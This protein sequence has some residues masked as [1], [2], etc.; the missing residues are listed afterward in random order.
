MPTDRRNPPHQTSLAQIGK[1]FALALSLIAALSGCGVTAGVAANLL[2]RGEVKRAERIADQAA[3]AEYDKTA[4][5]GDGANADDDA[6]GEDRLI[7][8]DIA[9]LNELNRQELLLI[10]GEPET[11]R[12]QDGI[13]LDRWISNDCIL[14]INYRQP[15]IETN[16]ETAQPAYAETRNLDGDL[17][18]PQPCLDAVQAN[19]KRTPLLDVDTIGTAEN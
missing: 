15:D 6:D 8:I 1:R 9:T 2:S 14:D 17:S 19:A 18:P 12:A 5:D 11:A 16:N 3:E 10:F 13:W 4:P 7:P